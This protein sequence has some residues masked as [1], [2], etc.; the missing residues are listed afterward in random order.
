MAPFIAVRT[1]SIFC[2]PGCPAPSPR[3]SNVQRLATAREAL[4]A[5]FRPC[6]RCRPL[7]HASPAPTDA[8]LRRAER[9]RP[10]LRATREVRRRRSGARSVVLA[11]LPTPL[12]PML[13]GVTDDGVCLLEFTDRPMLPTQLAVLEHRLKRPLVAG[14]HPLIDE[15]ER[16]LADYFAGRR[17]AF[18]LP[19]TAPGSPFQERTWATLRQ[20]PVG[21]TLTYE[22]L[23]ADA[24]RPGA[25]RAAGTAN[26]ANRIAVLIPCH[27]VIRKSGEVGGYGGGSWRK[28][29]LL[30][31][32]R[33]LAGDGQK[34][35][36]VPIA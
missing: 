23:A 13:A 30:D 33:R 18:D 6:L 35:M 5:G 36:S 1:T 11:T 21:A 3:P 27:R 20:I 10:I 19:L 32:E 2:R 24:G 29:W 22:E 26:G 34:V 8:E 25:Q 12:G 16:Q 9:L 15:L 28:A 17:A 4:F 31:H 7:E 14:R